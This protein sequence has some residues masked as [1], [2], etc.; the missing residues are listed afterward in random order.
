MLFFQ[1]FV[2]VGL[3]AINYSLLTNKVFDILL[4]LTRV[5]L[6]RFIPNLNKIFQTKDAV[7]INYYYL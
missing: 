7:V 3:R 5:Q 4:N 6:K 1:N 2:S